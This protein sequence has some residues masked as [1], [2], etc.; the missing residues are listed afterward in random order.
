MKVRN[1]M[2]LLGV[3]L[4]LSL[5]AAASHSA[6]D[7]NSKVIGIWSG[8]SSNSYDFTL[9]LREDKGKL[10]GDFE[11]QG[12]DMDAEN[13]QF[14]GT[15]LSFDIDTQQGEYSLQGTVKGDT[16]SGTFK[17]DGDSGTWTAT[18]GKA[19]TATPA[20]SAQ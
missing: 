7:V 5:A 16:I 3:L 20:A 11:V 18:R 1:C 14:D 8:S 15:S 17:S 12:N 19:D 13:L 10:Q 2:I 9:T 6:D 4:G